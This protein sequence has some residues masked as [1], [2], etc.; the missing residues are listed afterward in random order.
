M[1]FFSIYGTLYAVY[2]VGPILAS[3][4]VKADRRICGVMSNERAVAWVALGGESKG[5]YRSCLQ[6]HFTSNNKRKSRWMI[7]GQR[8]GRKE[9]S[10]LEVVRRI[11]LEAKAAKGTRLG[12][13]L[14]SRL[15]VSG[16]GQAW[17]G[18]SEL[19]R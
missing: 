13:K 8:K 16:G 12:V 2:L 10:H 18:F 11:R 6:N 14:L 7:I 19:A 4:S 5:A 15:G 3:I 17:L 9:D 1:S